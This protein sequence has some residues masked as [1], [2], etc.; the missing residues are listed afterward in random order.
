M[1]A[2]TELVEQA[3]SL[4]VA[5]PAGAMIGVFRCGCGAFHLGISKDLGENWD[6]V[7]DFPSEGN[8]RAFMMCLDVMSGFQA[9]IST[10]PLPDERVVH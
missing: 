5:S 3:T 9:G 1:G 10:S 6:V 7:A 4:V 8:A 2:R